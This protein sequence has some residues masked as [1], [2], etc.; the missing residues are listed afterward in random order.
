MAIDGEAVEDYDTALTKLSAC[1]SMVNLRFARARPHNP[2]QGSEL[3]LGMSLPR[4][5]SPHAQPTPILLGVETTV[6][7][8]RTTEDLGFS[9]VGGTDSHM[10]SHLLLLFLLLLILVVH[11]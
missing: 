3:P 5:F 11:V 6:E 7:I 10:V 4:S 1:H 8:L 9:I 2:R